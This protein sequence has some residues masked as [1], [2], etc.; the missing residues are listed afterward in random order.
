MDNNEMGVLNKKE[1]NKKIATIVIPIVILVVIVL[2]VSIFIF[3]KSN[4]KG[5]ILNRID[6]ITSNN[7]SGY[8]YIS[9]NEKDCKL[10][11]EINKYIK[12]KKIN[13]AV[14]DVSKFS[15]QEL[16]KIKKDLYLDDSNMN[17]PAIVYY[18]NGAKIVSFSSLVDKSNIDT[19]ISTVKAN[20]K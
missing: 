12:K 15:K 1:K 16:K 18:K 11:D 20:E 9:S 2:T 19:F 10:C 14:L 4:S 6:K 8:L 13:Y 7:S 3:I 5:I 17:Y